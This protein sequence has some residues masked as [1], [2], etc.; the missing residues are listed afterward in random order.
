MAFEACIAACQSILVEEIIPRWP[1]FT[2]LL[3]VGILLKRGRGEK[4]REA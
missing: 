4:K 2:R 3:P 1:S